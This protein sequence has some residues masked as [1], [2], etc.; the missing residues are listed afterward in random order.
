MV[1]EDNGKGF[2]SNKIHSEED[3][4]NGMGLAAMQLRSRMIG[5]R[6][7]I[8]SQPGQ[9]CRITVNLPVQKCTGAS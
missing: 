2:D 8:W 7:T 4:E 3:R 1:V 5:A 6:L 9:G